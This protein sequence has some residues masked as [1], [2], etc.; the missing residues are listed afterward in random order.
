LV[1]HVV[2]CVVVALLDEVDEAG[3]VVYVGKAKN[4]KRR[5]AQ[6]RLAGPGRRGKKPRTLVKEATS[7]EWEVF[8][9][10]LDACLEEV[11]LIQRLRP[12]QNVA[13]AFAFLYPLIGLASDR[14]TLRWCYTTSPDLFPD[15]GFHGAYRSR[16]TTGE[17]F[18]AL[19]R[20]L[21]WVGHPEP[22]HRLGVDAERDQHSWV[23]G[24][25]RLP[26]AYATAWPPFLRGEHDAILAD[27]ACRLL[28]KPSACAKAAE[29]QADL[30]AL[31]RF[32]SE[33]AH[34]LRCAVTEVGFEA[35]PVP[36]AE[37]DPLFLRFR[38]GAPPLG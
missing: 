34:A 8:P 20:L 11:R 7:I 15:Y 35:W 13:S 14:D 38:A 26:P 16:D 25:R 6:Y 5:L 24:F 2:V 17:A 1:V 31:A 19:M 9:T 3:A 32:F 36:Q 23:F 29:V 28:D 10:E 12:R 4:L 33:E 18:F 27:L 21:H 37:R 30:S 22:R